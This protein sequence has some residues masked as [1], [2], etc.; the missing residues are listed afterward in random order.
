MVLGEQA[1]RNLQPHAVDVIDEQQE[2]H[3]GLAALLDAE[4]V[5]LLDRVDGVA[6]G[7]G[8]ADHLGLGI[9]RLQQEGS[10]IR[11]AERMLAR[12]QHLAAVL[13]DVVGGFRLDTLA[14]RVIDRDEVPVLAAARH[15]RRRCRVAGR[16]GVV[17]PLN[18]VGRTGLAG[19]IGTGGGRRQERHPRIPQQRIDGKTNGRIRHV[20]DGV[21]TF[22][23]EP[24]AR[25]RLSDIGLVLVIGVDDFDLDALAA[26]VEILR[27]HARGFHRTHAVG[28]LEDAGNVVEHA[29]A[30][31]VV[32]NFR[33]RCVRRERQGQRQT[34]S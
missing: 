13:L 11:G 12:T 23:I 14:E 6:A 27:R 7:I 9:L 8:K 10:E 2:R 4:L 3:H 18:G 19:E 5:G 17:D 16:P 22:D 29:D 33:A 21:D 28:I 24:F 26:A 25:D 15:H 31:H 1:L 32:G 34:Q 20:D 30:D